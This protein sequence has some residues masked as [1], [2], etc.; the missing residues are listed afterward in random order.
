[1]T[2]NSLLEVRGI[3]SSVAT[4]SQTSFV[5][6]RR[7]V[8]DNVSFSLAKRT[9]L[10]ILGA[11]GSGKSTLARCIAGLQ[12]PDGGEIIF[13][14]VQLFPEHQN[15]KRIARQIQLLFQASGASL[16]PTMTVRECI[17]EGIESG[18]F[19]EAGKWLAAVGL[20]EEL[21][22]RRPAQISGGQKQRVALARAL[23]AQPR[24]LIL[25]EP[26]SALDIVTQQS[27]LALLKELQ[28]KHGFSILFITH[29]V[30]VALAFCDRVAVLHD[31][32]IVEENSRDAIRLAPRHPFT[33][34]L[35]HNCGISFS[36]TPSSQL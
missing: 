13:D 30:H 12:L 29:D 25:D 2:T 28:A 14:G 26:T 17:E 31:G 4:S 15:R 20:S 21:L 18:G 27:M 5:K 11:S 10:G 7:R 33:R 23:A 19:T 24:L 6:K 32:T 9:T 35:F 36:T 16:D 34:Q 22:E 8:L 1:M 3:S